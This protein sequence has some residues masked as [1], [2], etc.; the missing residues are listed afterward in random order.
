M[1]SHNLFQLLRWKEVKDV[2]LAE[3][4]LYSL[5]LAF[6]GFSLSILCLFVGAGWIWTMRQSGPG[7]TKRL[8]GP[9]GKLARF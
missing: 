3:L 6:Q 7:E 9:W 4:L 2:L 1:I 8:P 5:A